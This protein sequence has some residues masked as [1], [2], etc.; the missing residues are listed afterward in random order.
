MFDSI[1][2]PSICGGT[3]LGRRVQIKNRK[4]ATNTGRRVRGSEITRV[5]VAIHVQQQIEVQLWLIQ[6]LVEKQ[7][8]VGVRGRHAHRQARLR[9]TAAVL[10]HHHG[11]WIRGV[12]RLTP[13]GAR[14]QIA[15]A[16]CGRILDENVSDG[17]AAGRI[18]TRKQRRDHFGLVA[19][20]SGVF[21][22]REELAR[23]IPVG[24]A[25]LCH[26]E[27]TFFRTWTITH[28]GLTN[29]KRGV[30]IAIDGG[31]HGID[32][33]DRID[34]CTETS[35]GYVR[36]RSCTCGSTHLCFHQGGFFLIQSRNLRSTF[37]KQMN[38]LE[39]VLSVV[40]PDR[41]Y[42]GGFPKPE[43]V[44]EMEQQGFTHLVDLTD[45]QECPAYATSL[46]RIH[47]PIV[48][49]CIPSDPLRYCQMVT[50][51]ISE[52]RGSEFRGTKSKWMVHCRGGHGRSSMVCVSLWMLWNLPRHVTV[53][54]AIA[55]I[56]D[57]H[58][59]RPKLRAKWRSRRMPF[60]HQQA[61]FLHRMH[62]TIHLLPHEMGYYAW[63]LPRSV[64]SLLTSSSSSSLRSDDDDDDDEKN[65][66]PVEIRARIREW[67][68]EQPEH[69]CR[70]Q[71]TFVK[72][73]QV[74]NVSTAWSDFI[75][76][77]LFELRNDLLMSRLTPPQDGAQKEAQ[78]SDPD[79]NVPW[80]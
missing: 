76:E 62:K 54:Q 80:T 73:F 26:V 2:L 41:L 74:M 59:S 63:I 77:C 79:P 37:G 21:V 61:S 47:F 15:E 27:H 57:A 38:H 1:L 72:S 4:H 6:E 9:A 64:L 58:V 5:G 24:C 23:T 66:P 30:D 53:N 42:F 78:N 34:G 52:F 22:A 48:D 69:L 20:A 17:L 18:D 35:D 19:H 65:D 11:A 44:V 16:L 32:R 67:L 45:G 70:F 75:R 56:N 43:E 49:H 39:E 55:F 51:V 68:F 8:V 12:V 10:I 7:I 13:D 46:T 14:G 29:V 36:K 50:H 28:R 3:L 40:I 31:G 60:N 33:H 25:S 71:L